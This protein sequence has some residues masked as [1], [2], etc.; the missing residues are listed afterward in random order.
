MYKPCKLRNGRSTYEC[1]LMDINTQ[2]DF[3]DVTGSMP[4]SNAAVLGKSLRRVIAWAKWNSAPVVSSIE[5]HRKMELSDSGHPI[6]CEDGSG[7]QEKLAYTMLENRTHIEFD[8]TFCV[9]TD[10]FKQYQQVIFRKRGDDLLGNP[11]ADRFLTQLPVREYILFGTGLET[12]IKSA[13]LGLLTRGKYVTIVSDACGVWN[14]GMADLTLR[15]LAAKGARMITVAELL[16]RQLVR[17]HPDEIAQRKAQRE[18]HVARPHLLARRN[19][20]EPISHSVESTSTGHRAHRPL[21]RSPIKDRMP[22]PNGRASL[23]DD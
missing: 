3:A 1:V 14:E 16:A 17:R 15:Q 13:A 5:S 9:K 18:A 11:K 21:P 7:G 4:V 19:G 20:H 10:L 8:N 22:D 2:R 6:A 12:S 23:A